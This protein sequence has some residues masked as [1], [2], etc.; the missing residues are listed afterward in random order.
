VDLIGLL[1]LI[2]STGKKLEVGVRV[3]AVVLEAATQQGGQPLFM[4]R[5]GLG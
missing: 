2:N 4:V 3:T 1:R 5:I